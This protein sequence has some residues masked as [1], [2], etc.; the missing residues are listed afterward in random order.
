MKRILIGTALALVVTG[1]A[2]AQQTPSARV[3]TRWDA[4][5][6]CWQ[7]LDDSVRSQRDVSPDQLATGARG[8]AQR[9]ETG[10]R[11]C[12]EPAAT[13]VTLTTLVGSER[14]LEETIVADGSSQP[15]SD[16]ECRGTK[17]TEWSNNA[18]RLYSAAEIS[19]GD[20]AP[21]KISSLSMMTPGPTWVDIQMI[22]IDGRKNIRIRRYERAAARPSQTRSGSLAPFSGE[23]SW[24]VEDVT[25]ASAKL[26]PETVQAAL[27]EL[28][29]GFNLTGRQ[30][31]DMEKAGVTDSI[32]DLMVA[33]SYPKRFVIDRPVG[34]ASGGSG[35]GYGGFDGYDAMW[36]FYLDSMYWSSYYSPFTYRYW[37]SYDP[38]YFPGSGYVT[39][40]PSTAP[41]ASG[42]GRVVDGRGYTRVS[43][44]E[45]DPVRVNGVG[46]NNGAMGGS[47]NGG[48]SNTG[49]SGVS[50]GG[51]SSGGGGGGRTAVPR[52]PGD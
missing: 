42:E 39:I 16:A 48:S 7:L 47:S 51:Y 2:A 35:Y 10:T 37:G 22:D 12:V 23:S 1:S 26:A 4:W 28:G 34:T 50:S 44:R 11:V 31:L 8:R 40:E 43:T 14:A 13:G 46:G 29:S 30:L 5:L 52:P 3:D 9:I 33:L 21:R 15:V 6:G 18:P 24:T 32:V 19:C 17:R 36:P 49:D 25:E 20:Q 38:Y 45:P 27:V 41:V